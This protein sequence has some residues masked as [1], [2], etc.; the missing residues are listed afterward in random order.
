MELFNI[1]NNHIV[2]VLPFAISR[3]ISDKKMSKVEFEQFLV[4]T[5][6]ASGPNGVDFVSDK[7]V[8]SVFFNTN[9]NDPTL[10]HCLSKRGLI[11][12]GSLTVAYIAIFIY[13]NL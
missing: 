7:H 2:R 12:V 8:K 13:W 3:L 6:E 9:K 11:C 5:L 4:D 1:Y 10:K